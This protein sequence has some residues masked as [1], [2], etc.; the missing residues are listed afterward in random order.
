MK[1]ENT[2]LLV[3]EE[4]IQKEFD[5]RENIRDFLPTDKWS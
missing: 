3:T 2:T 1:H 5:I 4:T